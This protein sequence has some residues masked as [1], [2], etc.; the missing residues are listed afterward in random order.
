VQVTCGAGGRRLASLAAGGVLISGVAIEP[1]APH[2]EDR[3]H[4]SQGGDSVVELGVPC[5]H[6]SYFSELAARYVDPIGNV[7]NGIMMAGLGSV[8]RGLS[9]QKPCHRLMPEAAAFD[10]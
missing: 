4:L 10:V 9:L 7:G 1:G 2:L 8:R 3:Q 6:V 5:K